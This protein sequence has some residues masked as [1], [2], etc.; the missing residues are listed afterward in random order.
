MVDWARHLSYDLRNGDWY[1]VMNCVCAHTQ[2]RLG[3][4]CMCVR[5]KACVCALSSLVDCT[6]KCC[7]RGGCVQSADL[8]PEQCHSQSAACLY[9]QPYIPPAA[10]DERTPSRAREK[11]GSQWDI[12]TER[13]KHSVARKKESV[14]Q[15]TK[16]GSKKSE[17]IRNL[18]RK[19]ISI[20]VSPLQ[21]DVKILLLNTNTRFL[22]SLIFHCVTSFHR[23]PQGV[24]LRAGLGAQWD[25]GG[26]RPQAGL[27]CHLPL[28]QWLHTRG[29]PNPNLHHG[30]RWQAELEQTQT[31]L[32][33]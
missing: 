17:N 28:R 13:G 19:T 2:L 29:R 1:V 7:V 10:T 24:L 18:R 11:S 20:P 30:G 27:H 4:V 9:P 3:W 26:R 21:L 16:D 23:E 6:A 14:M 31:H 12:F 5:K 33:W 15:A 32:H 8:G 25:T 22:L